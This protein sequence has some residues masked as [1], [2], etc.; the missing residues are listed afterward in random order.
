MNPSRHAADIE[1]LRSLRQQLD[2]T[3]AN[4]LGGRREAVLLDLPAYRNAGDL[5]ITRGTLRSLDRLGV[6]VRAIQ[7]WTLT[8]WRS[9][10]RL[11]DDVAVLLHG[12]GN[13]G[14][15]YPAHDDYR[16]RV[17]RT[18]RNP[19]SVIMLP[20]SVHFPDRPAV[21]HSRDLYRDF[22]SA[23]Y[24]VRDSRSRDSLCQ[25]IPELTRSVRLCPDAAFGTEL[26]SDKPACNDVFVLQRRDS[27]ATGQD[28][29]AAISEIGSLDLAHGD[30][31]SFDVELTAYRLLRKMMVSGERM[32]QQVEQLPAPLRSAALS[33]LE[34][35]WRRPQTLVGRIHMEDHVTSIRTTVGRGR[36]LVTDRLHGHVAASL[37]GV[38]NVALNNIDGKVE[39]LID[40][41]TRPL[42]T[43]FFARTPS[44]AVVHVGN[45]LSAP[46]V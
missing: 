2:A 27:E 15:L 9:L 36:V 40:E 16:G 35:G 8:S 12:G 17:L 5:L 42:S 31:P 4:T 23:T 44:E 45:L 29:V 21:K 46:R 3:L 30:W 38:P 19:S 33:T 24:L 14:G 41:W 37:M 10:S 43:T 11:S 39:T 26:K 7:D 28:L 22:A 20:Q 13:F 6:H 1:H 18:V 34:H 32:R 25:H